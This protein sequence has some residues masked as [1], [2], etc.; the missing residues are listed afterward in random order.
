M[1][2]RLL[3][4]SP[5]FEVA[6]I[7]ALD[8]LGPPAARQRTDPGHVSYPLAS[9]RALIAI[10][11]Q[12]KLYQI[13]GPPWMD[14]LYDV[15]A[16]LPEG[17]QSSQV[18]A[19]LR[20]LLAERFGLKVHQESR[21]EPVYFLLLGK[22][23]P[24]LTKSEEVLPPTGPADEAP[25]QTPT[26]M[27]YSQSGD[28]EFSRITLAAFVHALSGF[29]GRP[30]LDMTAVPG[31]FE[32]TLH[33]NPQGLDGL[34]SPP[35]ASPPPV[36]SPYSSIFTAVQELGLRLEPRKAPIEHIVVDNVERTPTAN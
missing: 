24:R 31:R 2:F 16:K 28:L 20:N 29:M 15:E 21:T 13:D 35:W 36:S 12:V 4:A 23:G 9:V 10:A 27:S 32:I 25:R 22:G 17:S 3:M 26:K 30:V 6:S 11:F 34:R 19:M 33:A 1:I 8:G 5:S 18:P 14:N 7:R